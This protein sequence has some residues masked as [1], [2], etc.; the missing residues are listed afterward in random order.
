[1]I[2]KKRYRTYKYLNINV[3]KPHMMTHNNNTHVDSVFVRISISVKRNHNQGNSY[4]GKHLVGG[5]LTRSKV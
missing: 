3:R 5:W 1:M 4:R 2:Q